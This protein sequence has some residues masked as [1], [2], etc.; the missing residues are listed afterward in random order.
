MTNRWVWALAVAAGLGLAACGDDDDDNGGGTPPGCQPPATATVFFHDDVHSILRSRCT[1]CHG[2]EQ[3]LLP[4][5]ASTVRT[6]SYSATI[7]A[8]NTTSAAQSNLIRKGDGQV[9]HGGGDV[10]DPA[11]VTSITT[12][13]TECAQN[14]ARPGL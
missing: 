5:F 4:E 3:T 14:N 11:H 9:T 8:V 10:L 2:D 1:P 12:W 7:D 6:T 13:I